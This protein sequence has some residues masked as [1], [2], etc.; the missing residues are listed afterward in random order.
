[1]DLH[2]TK[3]FIQAVSALQASE[4]TGS[5]QT[6]TQLLSLHLLSKKQYFKNPQTFF[7]GNGRVRRTSSF[8]RTKASA[9]A[10]RN[11]HCL[12]FLFS[13]LLHPTHLLNDQTLHHNPSM[14]EQN[15]THSWKNPLQSFN[16]SRTESTEHERMNTCW[17]RNLQTDKCKVFSGFLKA[18]SFIKSTL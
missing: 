12:R 15:S 6:Q 11:S 2:L 10:A 4:L 13:V 16:V 17:Q 1:M 14:H 8:N 18:H 7:D 9:V 5:I 3:F